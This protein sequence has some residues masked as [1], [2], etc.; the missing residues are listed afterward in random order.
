[1][2]G[3]LWGRSVWYAW[4]APEGIGPTS[5]LLRA[6]DEPLGLGVYTGSLGRLTEVANNVRSPVDGDWGRAQV[7]FT[8]TAGTTYYIGA[9]S[10]YPVGFTLSWAPSAP[11]AN[12]NFADALPLPANTTGSTIEA[13]HEAGEPDFLYG[14]T[15]LGGRSVWYTYTT[16]EPTA[17]DISLEGSSFDTRL[18][19]YTGSLGSLSEVAQN[20]DSGGE[21]WSRL[22][23]VAQAGISYRVGI[24]GCCANDYIVDGG[25]TYDGGGWHLRPAHDFEPSVRSGCHPRPT[26]PDGQRGTDGELHGGGHRRPDP[27][28]P[29]AGQYGRRLHL[30][31]HRG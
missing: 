30:E 8:P 29:V 21:T 18:G 23:F 15:D 12:D 28:C 5:L 10:R 25:Q 16:A 4:T 9:G 6:S 2:G 1:M 20:D 11:P 7:A 24:G 3:D 22:S 31:Q 19:V 13:T 26:K 14:N 17:V 27:E